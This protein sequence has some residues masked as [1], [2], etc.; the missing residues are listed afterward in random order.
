M[1]FTNELRASNIIKERGIEGI[2]ESALLAGMPTT[3]S[4]LL[5]QLDGDDSEKIKLVHEVGMNNLVDFCPAS[6]HAVVYAE[7]KGLVAAFEITDGKCVDV[8]IKGLH[9]GM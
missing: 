7:E 4:M 6:G 2:Y 5:M 3:L 9:V 8:P 1:D